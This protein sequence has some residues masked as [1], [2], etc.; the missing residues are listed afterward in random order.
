MH[1]FQTFLKNTRESKNLEQKTIADATNLSV[2]AIENIENSDNDILLQNSS[3]LL[4]NQ[5]RRYCEYLEIPE[6]KIT[7]ILNKI[8]I[9]YYKKSKYGKLK[10]FDYLNRL[11]IIIIAFIVIVLVAKLIKESIYETKAFNTKSSKTSII[12]TPINYDIDNSEKSGPEGNP[13]TANTNDNKQISAHPPATADTSQIII[14]EPN[15]NNS[16]EQS[17]APAEINNNE[18]N[19][20]LQTPITSDSID[21]IV[22]QYFSK[23]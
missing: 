18:K 15:S 6:K 13:T 12:Y 1:N 22:S 19:Q 14:D 11:A 4:K 9:L 23:K 2:E 7:S 21:D 10:L 17:S 5:V 8:D 16:T 20:N 3:T